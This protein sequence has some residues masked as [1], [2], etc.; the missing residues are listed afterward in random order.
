MPIV[1]PSEKT[2]ICRLGYRGRS[3]QGNEALQAAVTYI[4]TEL[5]KS[6]TKRKKLIHRKN[7]TDPEGA[8]RPRERFAIQQCYQTAFLLERKLHR[9]CLSYLH[10][11]EYFD[12]LACLY[13]CFCDR[14]GHLSAEVEAGTYGSSYITLLGAGQA[15][16]P[17]ALKIINLFT[18]RNSNSLVNSTVCISKV[19]SIIWHH[20]RR[21][22]TK[23][24]DA[25]S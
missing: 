24:R 17:V 9:K 6:Q 11:R 14:F 21:C 5:Q 23:K 13:E 19:L 18:V 25:F 10:V 8:L 1:C 3:L 7:E 12:N 20:D 4:W 2:Q 15:D 16:I 22:C